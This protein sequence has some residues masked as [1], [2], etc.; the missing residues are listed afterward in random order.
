MKDHFD[1]NDFSAFKDNLC[2]FKY[3]IYNCKEELF[4][5]KVDK[6]IYNN[7][8]QLVVSNT[9]KFSFIS[10]SHMMKFIMKS[11]P[12]WVIEIFAM[13]NK[14]F[15]CFVAN[16]FELSG[17]EIVTHN[18]Y[19]CVN[20]KKVNFNPLILTDLQQL[21]L[22][23]KLTEKTSTENES[24]KLML[25]R[26]EILNFYKNLNVVYSFQ[27]K[28]IVRENFYNE[29]FH[30]DLFSNYSIKFHFEIEEADE[31]YAY[32]NKKTHEGLSKLLNNVELTKVRH[33]WEE[34]YSPSNGRNLTMF[35]SHWL[36]VL[37]SNMDYHYW[38]IN[39]LSSCLFH[40]R[41]NKFMEH[42]YDNELGS[43][44][45]FKFPEPTQKI[46]S[47]YKKWGTIIVKLVHKFFR[48]RAW[49]HWNKINPPGSDLKYITRRERFVVENQK[50]KEII[51]DIHNCDYIDFIE[52]S[53][54]NH[55]MPR[56]FVNMKKEIGN[57][58]IQNNLIDMFGN[59]SLEISYPI[60]IEYFTDEEIWKKFFDQE[61]YE[62]DHESESIIIKNWF[63]I[64]I[65]GILRMVD[66]YKKGCLKQGFELEP[67]AIFTDPE[68]KKPYTEIER[69]QIK[70]GECRILFMGETWPLMNYDK[71][72]ELNN[73]NAYL[74]FNG[75]KYF[76]FVQ[77]KHSSIVIEQIYSFSKIYTSDVYKF[78]FSAN[79]IDLITVA[80]KYGSNLKVNGVG[81]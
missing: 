30:T 52:S 13:H 54:R 40:Q 77:D 58:T 69:N 7:M 75:V 20:T 10:T 72:Y 15:P 59:R 45:S 63:M 41:Q 2:R 33:N 60:F 9:Q 43:D 18:N 51:K 50:A 56:V 53:W 11:Q 35:E 6:I 26:Q 4:C 65:L 64:P 12:N 71:T 23:Q 8:S 73:W 47:L 28:K 79:P 17:S 22:F 29:M 49:S 48:F 76:Y 5:D 57:I 55:T 74:T 1:I 32:K 78:L 39:I 24:A 37:I 36:D 61:D 31:V 70:E 66:D 80:V 67:Y 21:K 81:I 38:W 14:T 62:I 34:T 25:N 16:L 46:K 42:F 3:V 19:G 27:F 44:Y 68:N